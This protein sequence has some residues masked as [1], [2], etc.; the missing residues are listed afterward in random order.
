MR[1]PL[2][3]TPNVLPLPPPGKP[4][5]PRLVAGNTAL[6]LAK[7][8]TEAEAYIEAL[9]KAAINYRNC[10]D[11][12]LLLMDWSKL[13]AMHDKEYIRRLGELD[14]ALAAEEKRP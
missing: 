9:E 8:V 7:K 13:E 5:A 12:Y 1:T 3:G 2:T 6:E 4:T 10:A 14:A 11:N